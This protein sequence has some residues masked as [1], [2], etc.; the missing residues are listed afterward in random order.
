MLKTQTR[1][2]PYEIVS[3]LGQG[4][5]G[6]VYRAVDTRLGRQV[7]IKVCARDVSAEPG[8]VP[9]LEQEARAT[10]ALNHPNITTIYDIGTADDSTLYIAMELI[11]GQTLRDLLSAGPL[12]IKRLLHV[13]AQVAD[14]L[15][16]AHAA[17]I[18]HRDLKPENIMVKKDGLAKILDFGLAKLVEPI[19]HDATGEKPSGEHAATLTKSA[20][21]LILGTVS[22]MSPE[23]A[24][25]ERVDFTSD[26]FSLGTILYE[27]A[28]GRRPFRRET[29]VETLAAIVRDEPEPLGTLD[30]KLP[31]PLRW[32][33]ERCLAKG[34]EDRYGS[35]RDLARDLQSLQRHLPE[36][37]GLE[38][39][40][41]PSSRD[42]RTNLLRRRAAIGL[43]AASLAALAG[44]GG[45]RIGR[46]RREDLPVFRQLTFHYGNVRGARFAADGRTV[47]Y[48]ATWIG[49]PADLY[50]IRPEAPLSGSLGLREAGIFSVSSLGE[51]AVA[52]GCRLNWGEC[53][54][55][56]A[57][58]PLTGG[59]PREIMKD[60]HGADWAPDGRTLAAV[61]F[62]GGPYRLHYPLDKVLYETSGWISYVRVSPSGDRV[63]F[64]DHPTL[65]DIGGSVSVVEA[66]GRRTTVSA[67]WRSLQGLA[68]SGGGD[69]LWFTGSRV[70]KGGNLALHAVTLSGRERA[71]FSSPATL[72]LCDISRDGK[73]VLLQRGTPRAGIA[74][75]GA[76]A[77]KERD[78]SLFDR[79][80]VADLS[81]DGRTLLF[82]EWGV[83]VGGAPTVF[84]RGT[85]GS[86]AVR[87]GE[88]RPLALSPD[89]RW[90]LAVRQ[91]SPQQL[92]L[93][94]TG[95]GEVRL[96]P[97]GA[98]TEYLDWAAWSPDARRVFF[99]AQ[100]TAERRRT[101]VQDIAGGEPRP[102][103][104]DGFVGISLS[105]DA[106]LVAAFDRYGEYHLCP[107][108]AESEPQPLEGYRDGD[109][110]L[111][112]S[113][114]GR[115]L[116]VREAGSLLLRI[117]RLD[118]SSGRREL[119]KELTAPD[120]AALTD[121][122]SDPGQ[123]R[124][125][126][127]GKSYAYTHWTFAGE[128]YSAE[129]LR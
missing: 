12:P 72:K 13:A 125:T 127:D 22:Y 100:E 16:Q 5:M 20:P 58:V 91:Q 111:Q 25:G 68:W 116:F 39:G 24:K 71:V 59:T 118:L 8:L 9:R 81:A 45:F 32:I 14:G 52:V 33:I 85:D 105:P 70:S 88:G 126:P 62:S 108:G 75:L 40:G 66:T 43:L 76:G 47:V 44:A 1:L 77:A 104:P 42:T 7:A 30:P 38:S 79:S 109:M 78:L 74:S 51:M 19:A 26:Q 94:P 121:I 34:P 115:F 61:A 97:G 69:E 117:H 107:V 60:V 112:W 101:Y 84:L 129:G 18:V 99:A 103:M 113:A 63:A 123:V 122:G 10:S 37:E 65:G 36:L 49:M 73:R 54:G 4:G 87:L 55:T 110:V 28:A 102:V 93:L 31:A 35:T 27:M 41:I 17:G 83:A 53:T 120:P 90:A 50:I 3:L 21:G 15:A 56:L 96:L 106:K 86:D 92:V 46:R 80:T 67:G 64:F 114:D 128:L 2:G 98:I 29:T 82:Y 119:W 124:L 57:Q 95:P 89:G 6:A 48:A 11:D 23:Q